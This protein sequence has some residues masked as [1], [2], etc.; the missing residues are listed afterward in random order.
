[1]KKGR[2]PFRSLL[3]RISSNLKESE[4]KSMSA[5]YEIPATISSKFTI[6]TDFF[7]WLI[8]RTELSSTNTEVLK[9]LL[10]EIG[11]EDLINT[12]KEFEG[13]SLEERLAKLSVT[14]GNEVVKY[15]YVRD[16]PP[17]IIN[18]L[19]IRLEPEL[20]GKDWKAFG[21]KI[22]AEVP[23]IKKW[24]AELDK[25]RS[26]VEA[27]LRDWEVSD[28]ATLSRLSNVLKQLGRDDICTA[29]DLT[30]ITQ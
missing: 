25:G 27:M 30:R 17:S 26:A 14:K 15:K 19:V 12:I 29:L 10:G 5:N 16:L 18:E 3:V 28:E 9:Q 2:D 22:K 7:N 13:E 4:W 23:K 1:M 11:R 8:Q 6:A 20:P 24:D 21:E